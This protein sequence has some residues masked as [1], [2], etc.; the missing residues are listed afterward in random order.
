MLCDDPERWHGVGGREAQER[1]D[2]CIHIVGSC[3]LISSDN[4][5]LLIN[6]FRPLLFSDYQ[7]S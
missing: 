7:Y 3:F 4:H 6:A 1:G 5:G 2:M